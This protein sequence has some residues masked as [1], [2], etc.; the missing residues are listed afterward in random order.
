M[1]KLNLKAPENLLSVVFIVL[2]ILF[3]IGNIY[4]T[5]TAGYQA[6]AGKDGPVRER[7]DALDS[8]YDQNFFEKYF[9]IN[10]N[11]L[12]RNLIGQ[13]TMNLVVKMDNGYL[14]IPRKTMDVKKYAEDTI[15][16]KKFCD[17]SS[18]PFLYVEAPC[19]VKPGDKQ[20]PTGLTDYSNKNADTFLGLIKKEKVPVL[21]LRSEIEKDGLDF[22]SM[23]FRTDHHWTPEAG[24]W[25]YTKIIDRLE[26]NYVYKFNNR[27]VFDIDNFQVKVYKGWYLGS[28]GKRVGRFFG[29]VDDLS[30]ITPKFSTKMSLSVPSEDIV[31]R[32]SF[33]DVEI[34]GSQLQKRDYYNGEAYNAYVGDTYDRV[35]HSNS[36]AES[37]KKVLL[38]GDSFSLPVQTFMALAFKRMDV[39]DLRYYEQCDLY[40][41]IQK[42]KPDMVIFLYNPSML[43]NPKAYEFSR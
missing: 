32:G 14:T 38:L 12:V 40:T 6:A 39:L 35:I 20:L 16:L 19:D 18:I 15:T 28:R 43:E 4:P 36:G 22:Y 13:R 37:G 25:A 8:S 11:G 10:L 29:G 26:N 3:G 9:F 41:Y 7:I 23:F 42:S 27:A 24:F 30:I 2:I 21:D 31:R 1:K 33:A 5:I 34:D 17:Q